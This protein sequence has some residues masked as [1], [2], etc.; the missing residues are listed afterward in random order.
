MVSI[1]TGLSPIEHGV[2]AVDRQLSNNT[3]PWAGRLQGC[4][5]FFGVN[6]VFVVTGP[7]G[8]VHPLQAEVG[9]HAGRINRRL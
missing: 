1:Y 3:R 5:A 8:R 2:E 6:P 4:A 9:W 7:R